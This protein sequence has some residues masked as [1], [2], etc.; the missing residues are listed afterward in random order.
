MRIPKR[1]PVAQS[2]ITLP[3]TYSTAKVVTFLAEGPPIKVRVP[4]T[5]YIH[6]YI[7]TCSS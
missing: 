7:H 5:P 4:Y 3:T 2:A 1:N 6:T